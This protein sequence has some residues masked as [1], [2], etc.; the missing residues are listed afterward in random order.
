MESRSDLEILPRG[1][2]PATLAQIRSLLLEA[3]SDDTSL[4]PLEGFKL[5]LSANRDFHKLFFA[6]R[7]SCKTVGLL[8]VE[9]GLAK[10]MDEVKRAVPVLVQRLRAQAQAFQAMPCE[11]HARM[12]LGG[13]VPAVESGQ[14]D[15][16][17]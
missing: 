7:C 12:R 3:L 15:Q 1:G 4:T 8:S 17:A 13:R 11:A 5:D 6:A 2:E 9:V 10:T 14:G 16:S